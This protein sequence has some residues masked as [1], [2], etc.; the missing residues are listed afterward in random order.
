MLFFACVETTSEN[1]SAPSDFEDLKQENCD[2]IDTYTEYVFVS[3][4]QDTLSFEIVNEDEGRESGGSSVGAPEYADYLNYDY[5]TNWKEES[6]RFL[7]LY[8]TSDIYV[9]LELHFLQGK[10]DL[11][12]GNYLKQIPNFKYKNKPVKDVIKM[13]SRISTAPSDSTAIN[14]WYSRGKGIL[15]FETADGKIWGKV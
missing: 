2:W 7:H 15:K 8:V 6:E 11:I 10:F 9:E 4:K 1:T 3:N 12:D 14:V 5:R 13:K